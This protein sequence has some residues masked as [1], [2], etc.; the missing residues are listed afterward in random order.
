MAFNQRL[1]FAG[2]FTGASTAYVATGFTTFKGSQ[3]ALTTVTSGSTASTAGLS[4]ALGS[5]DVEWDSLAALVE[6][7]VTTNTITVASKWQVSPD[8][9]NWCDLVNLNGVA[10]LQISAAGTGSL[11]TTIYMH[12]LAGIN[13]SVRYLRLAVVVG[14]VTGGAGDNVTVS[15]CY[16]KRLSSEA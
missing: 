10:K 14:V 7:D 1:V 11:V 4:L 9:T 2:G 16:R 6:T 15:Y 12:P 3:I 13:P 8:N 5:Q